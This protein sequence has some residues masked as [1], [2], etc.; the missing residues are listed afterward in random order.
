[1]SD[2]QVLTA[3]R[4]LLLRREVLSRVHLAL[5]PQPTYP[6]ILV[7]LEELWTHLPLIPTQKRNVILARLKFKVSAFSQSSGMEEVTL[8]SEKVRQV[9]EGETVS[10]PETNGVDKTITTRFLACVTEILGQGLQAPTL[11]VVHHF[12]DCII[13]G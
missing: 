13:R 12:Y 1:M 5:P 11:R 9:L 8:L 7:D 6:L 3:I 10:F 2:F 4:G